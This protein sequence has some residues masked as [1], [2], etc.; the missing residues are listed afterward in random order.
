MKA[1]AVKEPREW[2]SQ[3]L[4][5]LG[6]SDECEPDVTLGKAYEVHTVV[7]WSNVSFFQLVGDSGIIGW[8]PSSVFQ[9][10]DQT[11][12]RDWLANR[13]DDE[14]SFIIGPDF[15]TS[16]KQAYQEMV[17]LH[18]HKVRLFKARLERLRGLSR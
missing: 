6:F 15:I 7:V 12:P 1:R 11:V 9:I 3:E 14:V 17:E 10:D 16:S 13:F 4:K 2:V 8:L 5:K 18:P